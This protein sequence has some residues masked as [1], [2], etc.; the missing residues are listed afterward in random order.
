MQI[1][2]PS[3]S[4]VL[5]ICLHCLFACA[6]FFAFESYVSILFSPRPLG[7]LSSFASDSTPKF[8]EYYAWW[9][10]E[11]GSPLESHTKRAGLEP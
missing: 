7:F 2:S 1:S 9:K 11:A 10:S 6:K 3:R 5:Q 8:I 4:S